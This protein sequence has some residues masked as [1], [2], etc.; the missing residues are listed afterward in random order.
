MKQQL[1]LWISS[2]VLTF[3]IGYT[4]NVTDKNYPVTGTFGI[5]GQ[6]VSYKLDKLHYGKEPYKLIVL[7]ELEDLRGRCIWEY[8]GESTIVP[9][10][11]SKDSYYAEIPS[12]KPLE[13]IF[14]KIIINYED[15]EY[16]IPANSKVQLM[17]YGQVP[18]GVNFLHFMLLYGGILLAIRTTLEVFN[19]NKMIRKYAVITT[20]FFIL[21]TAMINPLRNSYKLGAINN[22]IPE[23]SEIIEPMLIVLLFIWITGTVI[24]FSKRLTVF[25][26][27]ILFLTTIVL[28]FVLPV[29]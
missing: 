22:Y 23:I 6:K 3:L 13:K 16:K 18:L 4:K 8:A 17:F 12:R 1:I 19:K 29:A 14:Y 27:V 21:L 2:I 11:K 26:A 10:I 15:R 5:E 20:S 25:T 24:I 28:F 7:S 9:L